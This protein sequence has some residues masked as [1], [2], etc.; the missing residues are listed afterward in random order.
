MQ[1][2]TAAWDALSALH[3]RDPIHLVLGTGDQ[4]YNDNI[5]GVECC[6]PPVSLP[7]PLYYH[8]A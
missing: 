2:G 3:D 4:L 6:A 7:V 5:W 1:T 8:V